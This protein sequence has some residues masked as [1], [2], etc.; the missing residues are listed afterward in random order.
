MTMNPLPPQAYTKDILLKAYQWLMTQDSSI[1][2]IATTPDIL[3][4]LYLKAGRDGDSVLERPSI[5]NFKSEL[6]SLAGMMGELDRPHH[7][8]ATSAGPA[9]MSASATMA[10]MTATATAPMTQMNHQAAPIASQVHHQAS[11]Q[12]MPQNMASSAPT[13]TQVS[14]TEKTVTATTHSGDLLDVLDCGTRLMIQEV[15][16]EFNL[17]S[18]LE[19]VRMLIKIGYVKSKGMLK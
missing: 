15:K 19:A 11:P 3:V 13:Q 4:S 17:S 10:T 9:T 1:K 2:E 8:G 6:K 16:E 5:R 12:V 18:D 7:A 14:Y